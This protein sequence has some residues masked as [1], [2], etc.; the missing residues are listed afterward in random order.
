MAAS[1]T[2]S[3]DSYI[4]VMFKG[5]EM[6]LSVEGV[7]PAERRIG[8]GEEGVY[9]EAWRVRMAGCFERG[10]KERWGMGVKKCNVNAIRVERPIRRT[11]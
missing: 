9:R 1:A 6:S 2:P 7:A 10:M 8:S 4:S 3:T 11:L 5:I